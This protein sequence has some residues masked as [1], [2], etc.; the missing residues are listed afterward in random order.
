VARVERDGVLAGDV[1]V[2]GRLLVV[3][4]LRDEVQVEEFVRVDVVEEA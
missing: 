3:D 1:L 2:K 4:A